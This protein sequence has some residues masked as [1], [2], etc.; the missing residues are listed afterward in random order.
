[1]WFG[2]DTIKVGIGVDINETLITII[3]DWGIATKYNGTNLIGSIMKFKGPTYV[4]PI[5]F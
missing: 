4:I 1:L 2:I 3:I 5:L